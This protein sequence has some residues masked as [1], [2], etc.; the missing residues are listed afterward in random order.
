MSDEIF[1]LD[2][3]GLF[4]A[5]M[6]NMADSIY[7]K[8]RQC[9]LMRVSRKMAESLGFNN[10]AELIDKTDIELFGEEFGNR[11]RVDDLQV[12]E[13][14][15]PIV[16][17]VEGNQ[18]KTG[19]TNWTSTTKF[20]IRNTKG[21]IIGLLG[22]TREINDLKKIEMDLQHIA[23]HD[24]LTSLPNRYLFFDRLDQAILRAKRYQTSFA[25]LY[26]DLDRFKRINDRNGHD[27]GDK[28][29]VRV[30]K[31]LKD[32]IRV[33]DTVARLGGDEFAILMEAIEHEG[34]A[35]T[36]A[37]RIIQGFREASMLG[38]TASIGISIY[39][40][41]GEDGMILLKY[42]DDA[43]YQAKKKKDSF[44]MYDLHE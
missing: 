23:T 12:M 36:I 22:I 3:N 34:E 37:E 21:E 16:G 20:P 32:S 33:S 40:R 14:G 11:T 35:V 10:P 9:R 28:F 4:S 42:A 26:L 7:F 13:T 25:L 5:L 2:E 18:T 1:D 30:A 29:L 41:H 17:L 27:A 24:L 8:D 19:E 44:M 38:V 6:D 39:P 31:H 43:M 15:I